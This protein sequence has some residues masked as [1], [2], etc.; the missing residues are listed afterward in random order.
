MGRAGERR[1]SKVVGVAAGGGGVVAGALVRPQADHGRGGLGAGGGQRAIPRS[2]IVVDVA[3]RAGQ[4]VPVAGRRDDGAH[5]GGGR[6]VAGGSRG[7]V[8]RS[9]EVVD[10]TNLGADVVPALRRRVA[11]RY[12]W[13]GG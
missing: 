6:R 10:G 11:G 9:V 1:L 5:E 7:A 2:P 3:D 8:E 13:R 12:R 4:V